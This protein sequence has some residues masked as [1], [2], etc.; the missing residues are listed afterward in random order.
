MNFKTF[1]SVSDININSGYNQ[2]RDI[3]QR[4]FKKGL[5]FN[6]LT[7]NWSEFFTRKLFI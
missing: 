3:R 6:L 1:V 4:F 5:V 2:R 7:V